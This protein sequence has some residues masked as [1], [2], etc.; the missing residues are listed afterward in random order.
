MRFHSL[1]QIWLIH[2]ASSFIGGIE[3]AVA[4]TGSSLFMIFVLS[5]VTFFPAFA[6]HRNRAAGMAWR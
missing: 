5:G 4:A 6:L 1:E 2:A 3:N